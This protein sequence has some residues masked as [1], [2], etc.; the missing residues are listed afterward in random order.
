[1]T[2]AH[3]TDLLVPLA[4]GDGAPTLLLHPAGGG[5][6][7]YLGLAAE[8][9]ARG[10]VHAVRAAGLLPGE[11]PDDDLPTMVE[12]YA[13]LV[14]RP[15]ALLLGW[16]MGGVLAWELAARFAER[17][18]RPAVVLV[19]STADPEPGD[20]RL[21]EQVVASAGFAPTEDARERVAAVTDAHLGAMSRH[22]VRSRYDGPAL[23]VRCPDNTDTRWPS[24]ARDLRTRH[25]ACGH[26]EVFAPEHLATLVT[27]VKEFLDG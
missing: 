8:L 26:F 4:A 3:R 11:R 1:M 5:V 10:P 14:D 20:D 22:R 23:L 13:A 17:G 27:H 2:T 19:D 7:P 6:G 9:A 16:S 15:P 25:L 12:R 24:L 21:R 18:A